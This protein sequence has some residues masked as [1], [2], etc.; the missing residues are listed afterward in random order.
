[1]LPIIHRGNEQAGFFAHGL[2][3]TTGE[4]LLTRLPGNQRS[5]DAR[6]ACLVPVSDYWRMNSAAA[7]KHKVWHYKSLEPEILGDIRAGRAVLVLDLSNEG[8]HYDPAIFDE[9]YAW[10]EAEVLPAGRVIWLA[11]NR[12]MAQFA[13][14]AA[15]PRAGLVRHDHYDFFVKAMTYIFSKPDAP[16]LGHD[17]D[18]AVAQLFN[19]TAKDKLLLCLNATPRL[20][21]VLTVAALMQFGLLEASLV[22]FPG[23]EYTK[24]GA[25]MTGVRNF[26]EAAPTLRYLTPML[27]RVETMGA[28]KID[29]FAET[30]NALAAKIDTE[31]YARTFF[32]LVTETEF[33]TGTVDRV[34]EKIAKAFCMGHPSLVLGN[35][36]AV[37]FMT[38]LGFQDWDGVIDRAPEAIAA[39]PMRFNAIFAETMRQAVQVR[40]DPAGW[41]ARTREVGAFNI[42]HAMTGGLLRRYIDL[43]DRPVVARLKAQI[44][45]LD[46][47]L[48]PT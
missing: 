40:M 1:M 41:L 38:E 27:D 17:V 16:V 6:Y 21:R 9:L 45:L 11:Q 22:S 31:V 48:P 15:G 10:M 35:P 43:Y 33:T 18:A 44:G 4:A 2:G 12:A 32:S 29:S 5:D 25:S 24:T 3:H 20:H 37:R 28:L 34:T 42:R 19:Q 36:N 13:A 8:P 23:L 30:G 46:G 26:V 7:A 47:P 39:P 14:E